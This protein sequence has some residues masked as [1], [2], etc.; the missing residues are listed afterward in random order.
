[1]LISPTL[2]SPTLISPTLILPTKDQ[3][4]LFHLLNI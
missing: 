3:F 2:I 1:M 4:V